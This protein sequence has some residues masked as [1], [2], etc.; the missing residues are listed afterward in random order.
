MRQSSA[1]S[2]KELTKCD[3]DVGRCEKWWSSGTCRY[4]AECRDSHE[5]TGAMHILSLHPHSIGPDPS[6]KRRKNK[7][8]ECGKKTQLTGYRCQE[9]CDWDICLAC[10]DLES[11]KLVPEIEIEDMKDEK[12]GSSIKLKS[13][14]EIS[15]PIIDNKDKEMNVTAVVVYSH[16]EDDVD[17]CLVCYN[18]FTDAV[19]KALSAF[20]PVC[21]WDNYS[22]E[23]KKGCDF[24][25]KRLRPA[26][27]DIEYNTINNT[28]FTSS[29][30][31]RS[32]PSSS[33]SSSEIPAALC[34]RTCHDS[35][36]Q[37]NRLY[38]I[39]MKMMKME[40]ELGYNNS[41]SGGNNGNSDNSGN[42]REIDA[43]A[44]T[45]ELVIHLL[46]SE[47]EYRH[48]KDIQDLYGKTRR[49]FEAAG[50]NAN[51]NYDSYLLEDDIQKLMMIRHG[52]KEVDVRLRATTT[53]TTTTT[54]TINETQFLY[55][56][57]EKDTSISDTLLMQYRQ[58]ISRF[59][60]I[61][62]V[63][64]VAFFLRNNIMVRGAE[65][66]SQIPPELPLLTFSSKGKNVRMLYI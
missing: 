47:Q 53:T 57:Q 28:I 10:I 12:V 46:K 33:S 41:G 55:L 39:P 3:I 36:C 48:G 1:L 66:G 42:R 58:A 51:H 59:T 15:Q 31:N 54:T 35:D 16:E 17:C 40:M 38:Q 52:V 56:L 43:D 50:H 7:C 13:E 45:E 18:R 22:I 64:A 44:F 27:P 14:I 20:K 23:D 49:T 29:H 25:G 2:A 24:C 8:D 30:S 60:H 19:K 9:G 4:G 32:S 34:S 11:K 63:R 37:L 61:P 21:D 65:V 6:T 62:A 26:I 5:E